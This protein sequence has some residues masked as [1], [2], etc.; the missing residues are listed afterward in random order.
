MIIN[1][2]VATIA[3]HISF[4]FVDYPQPE[5]T[6]MVVYFCGCEHNCA[7]CQNPELQN[8]YPQDESFICLNVKS[9]FDLLLEYSGK[10][11]T[12]NVIL[13][14]G[15]PLFERNLPFTKALLS[16]NNGNFGFCI[17]TGY[18]IEYAKF[19]QVKYFEYIK[20]GKY[21]QTLKQESIKTNNAYQLASKNQQLFDRNYNLLTT[22]TGIYFF[23]EGDKKT[24]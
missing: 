14:G 11:R 16:I 3:S 21:I 18:D 22:P 8:P 15:D 7:G 2:P 19:N 13:T 20:T 5:A 1:D 24:I 12:T 17:F 10:Y 6:A 4:T 9:L 23:N